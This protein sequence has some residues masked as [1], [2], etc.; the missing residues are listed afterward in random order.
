MEADEKNVLE[1]Q[2]QPHPTRHPCPDLTRDEWTEIGES[3]G[4][5]E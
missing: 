5:F 4:W 1:K 2:T 3:N